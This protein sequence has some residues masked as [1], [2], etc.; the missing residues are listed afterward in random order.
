MCSLAQENIQLLRRIT[1]LEA[2][3]EWLPSTEPPKAE[4]NDQYLVE[5]D[6]GRYTIAFWWD[7]GFVD[8]REY[9]SLNNII[10]YRKLEPSKEANPCTSSSQ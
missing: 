2:E 6:Q 9:M 10:R 3:R 7:T 8:C 5:D 4:S 1:E